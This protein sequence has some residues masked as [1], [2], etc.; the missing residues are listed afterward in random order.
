MTGIANAEI[1]IAGWSA[2]AFAP[3]AAVFARTVAETPLGGAA[4][5]VHHRGSPV[6]DLEGGST[7]GAHSRHRVFSV[8]KAVTAV[9]TH[10]AHQR[11]QLDLDQPIGSFWPAFRRPSTRSI[12]T[13]VVLAHRAGLP[14]VDRVLST[15]EVVGDALERALEDQEPY[16]EPGSDH[17]YHTITFGALLD[18]IFRR[19]LGPSVAEY[20]AENLARPLD[21]GVTYGSSG[22]SN[23]VM[24]VVGGA[25]V[26]VDEPGEGASHGLLNAAA[27][28]LL[29]DPT[30]FNLDPVRGASLPAV[31]VVATARDLARLLASTCGPVDGLR[32]LDEPTADDMRATHSRGR[33]RVTDEVSHFGAGVMLPSSRI[34]LLGPG[35]F[36]HDGHGGARRRRSRHRDRVRLHHECRPADRRCEHRRHRP[37]GN[38][39]PRPRDAL[40]T[41]QD[42]RDRTDHTR[43]QEEHRCSVPG[44]DAFS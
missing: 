9:A 31:G 28:G 21:L 30:I 14:A 6:V 39:A 34:P 7:G 43:H 32:L 35:S 36:G 16:W 41:D 26:T 4:L 10:L 20:V 33:D 11:G 42:S 44:D 18:G 17:G 12:T 27:F 8:A 25:A 13:R 2:P 3:L 19:A 24:P 23:D 5:C 37:D 1:V 40:T 29:D 22:S 15:S 38:P